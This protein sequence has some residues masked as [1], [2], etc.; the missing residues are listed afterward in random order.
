MQL[1]G[2]KRGD[3][4]TSKAA[5]EEGRRWKILWQ[6]NIKRKI[7]TFLWRC[8]HNAIP[9]KAE[10]KRRKLQVDPTC[11]LCGEQEETIEH[12]FF[13]CE[14]AQRIWAIAPIRWD[15]LHILTTNFKSWWHKITEV[16][17]RR[18]GNSRLQLTAQILWQTW[19]TRNEKCFNNK[20]V[21]ELDIIQRA[22]YEW[23]EYLQVEEIETQRKLE[24]QTVPENNQQPI[25]PVA[26]PAGTKIITVSAVFCNATKKWKAGFAGKEY[27]DTHLVDKIASRDNTSCPVVA[28]FGAVREALMEARRRNWDKIQVWIDDKV[29]VHH[30]KTRETQEK[31]AMMITEDIF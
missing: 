10:L 9:V 24:C 3:A 4:G 7:R 6:M 11:Q 8:N 28:K 30:L 22:I 1:Q 26:I 17:N 29:M 31:E 5:E 18:E 2:S 15:G 12:L 20:H 13:H 21:L 16:Q 25:T 27:L 23:Q 14:R 19:K